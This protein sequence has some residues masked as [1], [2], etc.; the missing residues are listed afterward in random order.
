MNRPKSIFYCS[1]TI[2]LAFAVPANAQSYH[3]VRG[4]VTK[5]GTYVAPHYQTNPDNSRMNNWSTKGNTNP[6]TGKAGTVSP[7][8]YSPPK[9]QSYG[10]YS[11]SDSSED[12]SD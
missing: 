1:M 5:S 10:G 4:H 2:A 12:D 11:K 7:Y 8:S 6:F 9:V 3:Y